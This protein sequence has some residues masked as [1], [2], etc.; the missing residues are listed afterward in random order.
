MKRKY[1]Q[2]SD[3]VK[4]RVFLTNVVALLNKSLNIIL[5]KNFIY[6]NK[7]SIISFDFFSFLGSSFIFLLMDIN[8]LNT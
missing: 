4:I 1:T 2:V 6:F 7:K 3:K 8:K 5:F